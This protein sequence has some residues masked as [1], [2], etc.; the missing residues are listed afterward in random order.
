LS[1]DRPCEPPP[2]RSAGVL[3]WRAH[4]IPILDIYPAT[5]P[6]GGGSVT[7]LTEGIMT[8]DACG[9][10]KWWRM[11]RDP[12]TGGGLTPVLH[13]TLQSGLKARITAVSVHWPNNLVLCGNSRGCVELFPIPASG[14]EAGP[15]LALKHVHKKDRVSCLV[16]PAPDGLIYSAGR[17]G[18]IMTYRLDHGG[19]GGGWRLQATGILRVGGEVSIIQ[20][21]HFTT[22]NGG[23]IPE[24]IVSGTKAA[25][26][27]AWNNTTKHPITRVTCGGAKRAAA[28][29]LRASSA[30]QGDQAASR[31]GGQLD[32][33]LAYCKGKMIYVRRRE[34]PEG[35]QASSSTPIYYYHIRTHNPRFYSFAACRPLP[36]RMPGR[37]RRWGLSSTGGKRQEPLWSVYLVGGVAGVVV[38]R[39]GGVC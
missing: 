25:D 2:P 38:V 9:T 18:T 28:F 20:R 24:L 14:G 27:M 39:E 4:D 22:P 10:V 32:F 30:D 34:T 29:Q 5:V 6:R 31:G 33:A 1:Q 17:D 16:S 3:A 8:A 11:E 37:F 23:G 36:P 7:S 26:F 21:L 15:L 12:S 35:R 13:A 19:E